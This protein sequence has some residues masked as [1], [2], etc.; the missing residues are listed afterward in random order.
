M[1]QRAELT[2]PGF[3][4]LDQPRLERTG[5]GLALLIKSGID[6]KKVDGSERRSFKWTLRY[7]SSNLR[8]AVIYRI[9]YSQA[10]SVT[11]CVFFDE[12]TTYLESIIMSPEPF[13][14]T[15]D[16]NIHVDVPTDSDASRFQDLLSS[17]GLQRQP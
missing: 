16:F 9:P 12:L 5:G 11:T 7:G 2:L 10:H 14:I 17:M 8:I 6:A 4:L 13:P 15:G 1:A 3:N